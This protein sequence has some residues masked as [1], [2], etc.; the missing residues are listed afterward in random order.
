MQ[1]QLQYI[2]L[3]SRF[4]G[5]LLLTVCCRLFL[6][7]PIHR[8]HYIGLGLFV[9]YFIA[10]AAIIINYIN[11]FDKELLVLSIVMIIGTSIFECMNVIYR[12]MLESLDFSPYELGGAQGLFSLLL[13]LI[14]NIVFIN[15]NVKCEKGSVLGFLCYRKSD[16]PSIIEN[17]KAIILKNWQSILLILFGSIICSGLYTVFTLLTNKYLNPL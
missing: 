9:I 12:W 2:T 16:Y 10:N 17:I 13:I 11:S 5:L 1:L 7:I 3:F 8:H 4:I 15:K 14:P 6:L